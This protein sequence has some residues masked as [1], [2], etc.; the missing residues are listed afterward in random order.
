MRAVIECDAHTDMHAAGIVSLIHHCDT[1]VLIHMIIKM[2]CH[3]THS[4]DAGIDVKHPVPSHTSCQTL[5]KHYESKTKQNKQTK[6]KIHYSHTFSM[7]LH[8]HVPV[9]PHAIHLSCM[10]DRCSNVKQ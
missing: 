8:T 3:I 9:I 2:C 7:L 1:N 4:C 6:T 5:R 10:F